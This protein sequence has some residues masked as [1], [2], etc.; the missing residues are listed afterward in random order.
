MRSWKLRIAA[1]EKDAQ[2]MN[3]MKNKRKLGESE[4]YLR[5]SA[6]KTKTPTTPAAS[7][8]LKSTSS[9]I[10]GQLRVF[11]IRLIS[12]TENRDKSERRKKRKHNHREK[13]Q[14]FNIDSGTS[15]G[16]FRA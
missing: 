13:F 6:G 7:N 2:Q 12:H 16:S 14:E 8:K 5:K 15:F 1:A 9:C 4:R 11:S 10:K 3:G